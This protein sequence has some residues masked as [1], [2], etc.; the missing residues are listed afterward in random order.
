MPPKKKTTATFTLKQAIEYL[1]TL[2]NAKASIKNWSDALATLVHYVEA[3][4]LAYPTTL[5]K[6]EM[7]E[8]YADVNVVPIV[9]DIASVSD[10]I[11]NKMMSSRNDNPIALDTRKQVYLAI[12]RMTQRKAPLQ[13][14]KEVKEFYQD[15]LK[16][17]E[18]LSNQQRNKNEAKRANL[19]FPDFTWAVVQ[20]E[21]EEFIGSR[22]FT[23][24]DKGRKDLRCAVI[25]GLYVLQRPR[26][27]EDY[28][29]LQYYSKK[30]NDREM[31]DK[32]II[33][34][35]GDKLFFSID[36]FKTRYRVSGS[37][38]QKKELLP[39]YVKEVN[40]QLSSLLRDYMKKWEVKDMSKL[41]TDEKR[42]KK[43]Y[44]VFYK[45]TGTYSD[46]YDENSFSKYI[47]SCMR[48]VFNNR[49]GI[50]VN[51]LRHNYNTWLS[52]NI[53][54]F[55]DNQLQEIA[56]DVGDTPRNLPT[57][58]R[59]RLQNAGL[60]DVEKTQIEGIIADN[61]YAR[62]LMNAGQE[63]EGSVGDID[64]VVSPAPRQNLDITTIDN[65]PS[66][67]GDLY[68]KLGKALMEA[69]TLKLMISRKLGL[70]M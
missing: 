64:E 11:D 62:N 27:V 42:Q 34:A 6:A 10:I 24:T 16:E 49:A 2:A 29:S 60:E 38:S 13:L 15:K 68:M 66:D 67:I 31:N 47:S 33:Y 36:K 58:L 59:Y 1:E 37:A 41:T 32:N 44:Y 28:A 26:R 39:R 30:P 3:G 22:A 46:A 45:E 21:F 52:Q 7:A 4:D 48:R 65:A 63:E 5:K 56:I 53:S 25:V 17:V 50:T 70:G 20:K 35:E 51:T 54:M 69:E 40:G 18:T 9:Y 55:N 23:N 61:E 57:N 8:K 12:L 43:Q 19:K 14:S